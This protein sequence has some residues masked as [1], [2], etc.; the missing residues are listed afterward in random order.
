MAVSCNRPLSTVGRVKK[1]S[2]MGEHHRKEK[3]AEKKPTKFLR[4]LFKRGF[5]DCG[6]EISRGK[7]SSLRM[8]MLRKKKLLGLHGP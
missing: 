6:E 7:V 4:F 1:K 5:C 3:E 8:S 2:F